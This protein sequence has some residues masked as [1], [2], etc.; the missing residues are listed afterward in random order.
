MDHSREE[1]LD[2]DEVH[3]VLKQ[4]TTAV[5]IFETI[6]EIK[7]KVQIVEYQENLRKLNNQGW[8]ISKY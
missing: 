5:K 3:L 1:N 4:T 7:W 6:F 8:N 2:N